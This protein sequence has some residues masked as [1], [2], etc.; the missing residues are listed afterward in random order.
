M[1]EILCSRYYYTWIEVVSRKQRS[2]DEDKLQQDV[3]RMLD[4]TTTYPHCTMYSKLI[5]Y[6]V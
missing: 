1:K 6:D 3:Q 2:F 4:S 5:P